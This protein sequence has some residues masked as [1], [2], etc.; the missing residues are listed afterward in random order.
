MQ[1]NE[2]QTPPLD[3]QA[4]PTD[5][6]LYMRAGKTP[7]ELAEHDVRCYLAEQSEHPGLLKRVKTTC[8]RAREEEDPRPFQFVCAAQRAQWNAWTRHRPR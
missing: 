6:H 3:D 5:E 8:V 7:A 4:L 1:E 2:A